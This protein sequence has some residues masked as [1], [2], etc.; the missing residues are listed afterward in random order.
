MFYLTT[1]LTLFISGYMTLDIWLKK[2]HSD[3]ARGN[4]L[5]SY[6]LFFP[7][8]SKGYFICTIPQTGYH[9]S[10]PLLHQSWSTGWSAN[11]YRILSNS[12]DKKIESR[13]IVESIEFT[14]D[15]FKLQKQNKHQR[16]GF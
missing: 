8:S 6:S 16:I 11:Y 1:L 9:R 13:I 10:W 7:I 2:P 4:P 14:F 3:S 12:N 5:P 15:M